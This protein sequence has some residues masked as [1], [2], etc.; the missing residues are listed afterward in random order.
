MTTIR[1]KRSPAVGGSAAPL[2]LSYAEPAYSFNSGKM[3]IGDA[4]ADPVVI[5]G[6]LYI[7]FMDHTHGVVTA[8]SALIVDAN[9]RLNE[10]LVDN[11]T[12][13]GNVISSNTGTISFNNNTITDFTLGGNVA[14]FSIAADSGSNDNI[15]TGQTITFAGDTGITTTVADNSISIDLDD[16][17][18]TPGSYGSSTQIPTFT[19]D[20]QGRLTAAGVASIATGLSIQG[21]SGT[22]TVNLLTDTLDISGNTGITTTVTNNQVDID[23]ND[24]AVTP[25]SYGDANTVG[26]FTVDQQGRL[27]AAGSADINHD[28]LL[29]YIA[30]EHVGHSGVS[31]S[32]GVGLSGGG[33]ITAT[34]TLSVNV[35]GDSSLVA[36]TSGLFVIDSTLSIATSQLTGDVALGTQTSGDYVE[37]LVAGTGVTIIDNSGEG[38]TPTIS[39]GQDVS[40]TANVIFGNGDFQGSL[41]IEGDLT[42]NGNTTTIS[43]TNLE[44]ED[45]MIYLNANSTNTNP[46]LGW[47]GNYDT[48]GD[49]SGYAHTGFFR[50]A[51]DGVFKAYDGYIPEPDDSPFIDTTHASFSL[52]DIQAATF[53][54]DLQGNANTATTLETSRNFSITGDVVANAVSFDGSGNVVLNATIQ[55]NS[56][57]LGTDT[58][59]DYVAT[60][61]AN[62]T[63]GISVTG[64]GE[65]A[66]VEISGILATRTQLGVASFGGW[67]NED[68]TVRQFSV[69]SGDVQI[70]NIDGGTF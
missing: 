43:V 67:A 35:A 20:Q 49:G 64:T 54:G 44:V 9:K 69:T 47:A 42:V 32:A 28:T 15:G 50:D 60:V 33:D 37:S 23:L 51:T 19:V 7:G 21:D 11:I 48:V 66:D 61:S 12:I 41:I 29:N 2:S 18:V 10:L 17:S 59:G 52:A 5:G 6:E 40:T 26:T 3:F 65:G 39:I 62:N 16:T 56:V 36:N 24:T 27:T 22:D 14:I 4:N 55:P 8:N 58:T 53:I 45:N 68:E 13:D 57:A 70:I 63:L 46:D 38:A 34:R 30:D 25:G 1:L 31:I